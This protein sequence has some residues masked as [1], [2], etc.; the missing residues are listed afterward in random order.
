MHHLLEL[1]SRNA[2]FAF[3]FFLDEMKLLGNIA[4]AEKQHA[5]ARQ[6]V[7]PGAAGFLIVALQILWQI[8][9][10]DETDVRFVNSHPEGNGRRDHAHVV[11]QK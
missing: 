6:A 3:A 1:R 10:H 8:V 11:A 7:A 2:R 9:M 5:F 4:G